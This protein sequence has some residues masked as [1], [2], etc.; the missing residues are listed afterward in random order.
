MDCGLS[1]AAAGAVLACSGRI[2]NTEACLIFGLMTMSLLSLWLLLRLIKVPSLVPLLAVIPTC[3]PALVFAPAFSLPMAAV[4]FTHLTE[5]VNRIGTRVTICAAAGVIWAAI[6]GA[7]IN[8]ILLAALFLAFSL[9]LSLMF[10]RRKLDFETI[11]SRSLEI[12]ELRER[13]LSQKRMAKSMEHTAKL[14]ERNRLASRIHDEIGHGMSG[15]ILLLE[16][17]QAILKDDPEGARDIMGRVTENLRE[18]VDKIRAM[19]REE[20]SGTELVNLSKIKNELLKFEGNHPGIR[21]DLDIEGSMENIP[22]LI[23]ISRR[24][25]R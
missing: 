9:T 19:L 10:R 17:A 7:G 4:T 14:L 2:A 8:S 21:T 20:R 24:W 12:D 23:S 15:S 6:T 13:V 11:T 1:T 18:S 3:V 16:G 5:P 22:G 25:M